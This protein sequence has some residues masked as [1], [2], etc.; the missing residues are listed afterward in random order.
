MRKLAAIMFTDIVGYS[1]LMSKDES[2][3]LQILN[4]NREIQMAALRQFNGEFIKEIGDGTLS[5]FQSSWDAVNCAVDIQ[6]TLKL[7]YPFMLRIGIHIG[8]IVFSD[9]DVYGDGVNIASRI[10]PLCEPGGICISE[11]VYEDI[12]NKIGFEAVFIGAKTL[13]NINQPVKIYSIAPGFFQINVTD[14]HKK[15]FDSKKPVSEQKKGI[16]NIISKRIIIVIA[17]LAIIISAYFLLKPMVSRA[18]IPFEPT[19]IAVITFENQTGDSSF[20]Y[21]Q[22]AIPNLLITNLEQSR[23]FRVITWERMQDILNQMGKP[24]IKV[25]DP[26]LGFEI[27]GWEGCNLIVIGSYIKAGNVFVTDAKVL[28]VKSKQLLKSVSAKGNGIASIL[29]SQIDD[30]SRE[31]SRSAGIPTRK[32]ESAGLRV[33]DVTTNS[34]TAYDYFLK[35]RDAFDKMYY[36][37]ARKYFEKAIMTDTTFAV[38]WLYLSNAFGS[39]ENV[40][41]RNEALQKAYVYSYKTTEKE[42]L[43][44]RAAYARTFK[45]NFNEEFGY[46]SELVRITTKEKRAYFALGM[47]Y[48]ARNDL[49]E[50]INQFNKAL[51]L[52]PEYAEAIN[53]IAYLY[54]KQGDFEKAL[55]YFKRYAILNPGDANPFDSMGDLLWQSGRLDEAVTEYQEALKIKPDFHISA[56]KIVYINCMK[57]NYTEAFEWMNRTID[58]APSQGTKALWY[59]ARAFINDWCGKLS[60]AYAD[61]DTA[62]ELS[63]SQNNNFIFAGSYWLQAFFD[64][65]ARKLDSGKYH[66]IQSLQI[67]LKD[68]TTIEDD[69]ISYYYYNGLLNIEKNR[70]DS[71]MSD[72]NRMKILISKMDYTSILQL[73]YWYECL[74]GE[75]HIKQNDYLGAIEFLKKSKPVEIPDFSFPQVLVYNIPFYRDDLAR[76][77]MGAERMDEAI[78]E[79]ERLISFNPGSKDRR[80]I[81]PK[82]HYYLGLLYE[83]KGLKDKAI[84]QYQKFLYLWHDADKVFPEPADAQK[85]LNRLLMH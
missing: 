5:I 19:P 1:A 75:M 15:P 32:I 65:D 40:Q 57:E 58:I 18:V 53:Q 46:L 34:M 10:E 33:I 73:H 67:F 51:K 14:D 62:R 23:L 7:N 83:K 27:C 48:K 4:K 43:Y 21:L 45:S 72:M 8:D 56:A 55:A 70:L 81:H 30:L 25:I 41:M 31:I 76:A 82:N 79:Y 80:L 36:N 52:D 37:D 63:Q 85:R 20:N 6:K 17:M 2:L 16:H 24:N 84:A 47:W 9:N 35:G 26:E 71:A 12:H 61:L 44:I 54:M 69:S 11:R 60:S 39:L 29:E 38:A 3:A 64:L 42:Q 13:K 78:G 50:S 68:T 22:K 49:N 28:D 66:Y 74:Y 59:W 77:Y